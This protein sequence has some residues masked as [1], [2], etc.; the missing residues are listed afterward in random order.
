MPEQLEDR[1]LPYE[2]RHIWDW[3]H[4]L[5]KTRAVGMDV[6][7][8]THQEILAWATLRDRGPLPIEVDALMAIDDCYIRSRQKQ[9]DDK[10]PSE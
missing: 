3:W 8:I 4:E 5:H 9:Q 6:C 7:H 2:V 1:P 10:E